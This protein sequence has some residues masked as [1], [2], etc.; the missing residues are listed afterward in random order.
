MSALAEQVVP[1][2]DLRLVGCA[3]RE[4]QTRWYAVHCQPH[5]ERGAASHLNNQ[6]FHVFLPCRQKTRRH[7]RKI[8]TVRVPF[9]PSYLFI[10]LDLTRDQWRCVNGTFGVVRIVS[11]N[12]RPTPAPRGVIE[13]LIESCS[14][15]GLLRRQPKLEI[16]S[17]VRVLVGPF[18]DFVGELDQMTDTGR[19]RVLLDLMGGHT[20]VFLPRTHV[21]PAGSCL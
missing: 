21:V 20:P 3:P 4:D 13:A 12:D 18:A 11:Q 7:A 2:V 9:F 16:G 8:E 14:E 6:D 17:K 15:D 19:V 10:R 1:S 5:R